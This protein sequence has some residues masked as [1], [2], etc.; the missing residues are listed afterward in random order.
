MQAS[1]HH[2]DRDQPLHEGFSRRPTCS[3]PYAKSHRPGRH[4][5]A[6]V[7]VADYVVQVGIRQVKEIDRV[8]VPVALKPFGTQHRILERYR[9][10]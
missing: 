10:R 7:A 6:V 1:E 8:P 4:G 9:E 5:E 2:P 3:V